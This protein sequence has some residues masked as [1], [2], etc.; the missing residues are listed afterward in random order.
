MATSSDI[1]VHRYQADPED[2]GLLHHA[3]SHR[4]HN[5]DPLKVPGGNTSPEHYKVPTANREYMNMSGNSNTFSHKLKPT[6]IDAYAHLN[7]SYSRN[8]NHNY[9]NIP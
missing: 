4:P 7:R 9:L 6:Q 2:D 8:A 3:P 1:Q 5:T